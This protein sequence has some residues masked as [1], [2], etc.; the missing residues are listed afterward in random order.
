MGVYEDSLTAGESLQWTM[1]ELQHLALLSLLFFFQLQ[2]LLSEFFFG[3][4]AG[5]VHSDTQV[6]SEHNLLS[7]CHL[8]SRFGT[9]EHTGTLMDTKK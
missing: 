2:V 9:L 3:G 5:G 6:I 1:K 8:L 4:E 7:Q